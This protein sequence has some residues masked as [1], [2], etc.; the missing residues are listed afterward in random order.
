MSDLQDE[1]QINRLEVVN[2]LYSLSLIDSTVALIS[3][4]ASQ[5]IV[6]ASLYLSLLGLHA[7][8]LQERVRL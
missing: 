3:G 6:N 4:C 8:L 7:E 2:G 1:R 5:H